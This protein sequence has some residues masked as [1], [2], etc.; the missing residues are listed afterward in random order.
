[1]RRTASRLFAVTI[2]ALI[3]G[4]CSHDDAV[5][6]PPAADVPVVTNIQPNPTHSDSMIIFAGTDFD[7][8]S[9]FELRQGGAVKATLVQRT[10]ATGT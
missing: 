10:F 3:A 1:M 9:T 8:N 6:N 4:R 5:V 7:Q 2:L